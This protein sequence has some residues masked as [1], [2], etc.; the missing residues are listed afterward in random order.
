MVSDPITDR[1]Q[2]R[3][4]Q[5]IASPRRGDWACAPARHKEV[6]MNIPR[7]STYRSFVVAAAWHAHLVARGLTAEIRR[8]GN[9]WQVIVTS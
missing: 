8:W 5:T 1:L 3:Y 9:H 7:I 2:N 4:N 6:N